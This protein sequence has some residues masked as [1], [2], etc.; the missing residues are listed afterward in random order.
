MA[1]GAIEEIL[2]IQSGIADYNLAYSS[3]QYEAQ[4]K[5][6]NVNLAEVERNFVQNNN[7]EAFIEKR[8]PEFKGTIQ[9]PAEDAGDGGTEGGGVAELSTGFDKD[10]RP[11]IY[12][13]GKWVLQ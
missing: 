2:A 5:D 6:P 1:P 13:N 7:P 4:M 8:R 3:A 11:I 12:K 10:N 9:R